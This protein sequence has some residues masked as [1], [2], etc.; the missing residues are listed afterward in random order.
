MGLGGA[1]AV[2]LL[3]A[4]SSH[5][6]VPV[7]GDQFPADGGQEL[8]DTTVFD[9]GTPAADGAASACTRVDGGCASL[10]NCGAKVNVTQV[11]QTP[12][13]ASGG[14][15]VPGT[16]VMTDVS[17][18]TGTGGATGPTGQWSIE[19]QYL[20]VTGADAG[21]SLDAGSAEAGQEDDGGGDA[22][23][24]AAA[25]EA[26][27]SSQVFQL[28]DVIQSDTSAATTLTG[29]VTFAPPQNASVVYDCPSDAG[30]FPPVYTATATQLQLFPRASSGVEVVTY[31]KM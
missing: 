13:P 30:A 4:C 21:T 2:S 22:G 17:I 18:Y 7:L 10:E 9:S 15:V 24:E 31:T 1:A 26:G 28:L 23:D 19:T 5:S 6:S 25:N 3:W 29:T 14:T 27:P 20:S 11:A 12:P 8:G 16:Y